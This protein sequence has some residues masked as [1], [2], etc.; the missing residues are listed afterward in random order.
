[1]VSALAGTIVLLSDWLRRTAFFTYDSGKRR[2]RRSRGGGGGGE[3]IVLLLILLI[4]ILAPIIA[5]LLAL[6][7]SRTR[8]YLADSSA[9]QLTRNPAGLASALRKIAT[10][11]GVIEVAN[12]GTA[13][14]FISDPLRR[15]L[16]E[17]E[18]LFADLFS[19]HPPIM[20]R[21]EI[22]ERMAH[23]RY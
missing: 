6:A 4:S 18:G 22:L 8:E 17:K 9:V 5:R 21:I 20:K 10:W 1:M 2:K 13:H 11:G 12:Q 14:L 19:T 15:K 16:S 7:V 3:A 23:M